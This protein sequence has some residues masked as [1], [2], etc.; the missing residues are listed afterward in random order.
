MT[1]QEKK[2]LLLADIDQVEDE[3]FLDEIREF[4]NRSRSKDESLTLKEV[5]SAR[6]NASQKD[7]DE[8]RVLTIAEAKKR[9]ETW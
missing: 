8:G 1:I 2:R 4:M 5:L 6:A 7:I 9:M 3:Q